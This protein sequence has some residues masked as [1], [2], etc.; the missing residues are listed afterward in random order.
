M[1]RRASLKKHHEKL[2]GQTENL[3]LSQLDRKVSFDTW[4]V[5]RHTTPHKTGIAPLQKR[6]NAR[7]FDS[8]AQVT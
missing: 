2:H 7:L 3:V 1:L 6:F 4:L 5:R 8:K